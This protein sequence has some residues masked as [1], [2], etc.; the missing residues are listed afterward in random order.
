MFIICVIWLNTSTRWPSGLSRRS[1]ASSASSFPLS[2]SALA[3]A[4]SCDHPRAMMR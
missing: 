1:S 2:V 3:S 4:Y